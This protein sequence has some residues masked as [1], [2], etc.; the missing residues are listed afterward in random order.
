[1]FVPMFRLPGMTSLWNDYEMF[2]N[3]RRTRRTVLSNPPKK[4]LS[5]KQSLMK[6]Y[7]P[8]LHND[9]REDNETTAQHLAAMVSEMGKKK[10]REIVL[11]PLLRRTYS[12][13]RDFMRTSS[14]QLRGVVLQKFLKSILVFR[15]QQQ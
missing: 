6:R 3:D 13:R 5:P 9:T 15:F 7:P 4:K 11:L 10:P 14:L 1:M 2:V 8:R 12:A